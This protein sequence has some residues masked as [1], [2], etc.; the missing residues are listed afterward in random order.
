M[1][2]LPA[3]TRSSDSARLTPAKWMIVS[4]SES[5]A[6]SPLASANSA[7]VHTHRRNPV[8]GSES[9][10][11]VPS[12]EAC[13]AGNGDPAQGV[14]HHD[15]HSKADSSRP[16]EPSSQSDLWKLQQSLLHLGE[17]E[18]SSVVR[19]V[20]LD[21]ALLGHALLEEQLVLQGPCV[22]GHPEVVVAVLSACLLLPAQERLVLLLSVSCADD[23]QRMDYR[24]RRASPP[25]SPASPPCMP[26]PCAR[27]G[28]QVVRWRT[29]APPTQPTPRAT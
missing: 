16:M 3:S 6:R 26:V 13:R 19:R 18:L 5:T 23:L 14:L 9:N 27:K 28:R 25:P 7:S 15:T 11:K 8:L 29:H 10:T 24:R 4:T 1:P 20:V 21:E 12:E 2:T 22:E 17:V